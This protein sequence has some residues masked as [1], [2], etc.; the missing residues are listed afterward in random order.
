[1]DITPDLLLHAYSVGVF[2]MAESRGAEGVHW[3]QPARRG[4]FEL[5]RFHISRSLR[6]RI[7]QGGYQVAVNRDFAG[8]VAAC[9]A[10]PETWINAQIFDLYGQLHQMGHAHSLEV[11]R[12]DAL[13]GGVYGV[14]IGGAFFGESMFSRQTDA[15]KI[16][17]AYLVHRLRAGG[18]ALFDTQYLTP[19][20]ASLGAVEMSRAAY[21]TRLAQALP[22]AASFTPADYCP[23]TASVAAPSAGTSPSG[24]GSTAGKAS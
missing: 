18:F 10:R 12:D 24:S 5:T 19:H 17:L 7:L 15:S 21:E 1:M 13:I 14:A 16:A 9:A 20:L 11:Y 3:M 2:P 22:I 4:V 8:T 23:T 6:K